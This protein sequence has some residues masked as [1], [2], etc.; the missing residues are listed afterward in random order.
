[1]QKDKHHTISTICETPLVV[2]MK[3]VRFRLESDYCQ[4]KLICPILAI[5]R[6]V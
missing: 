5:S 6:P 4:M 1:M 2:D 3:F